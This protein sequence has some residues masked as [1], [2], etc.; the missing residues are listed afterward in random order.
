MEGDDVTKGEKGTLCGVCVCVCAQ[1]CVF[2][3]TC[4]NARVYLLKKPQ[5]IIM[6]HT[7][8][9]RMHSDR[10]N[11]LFRNTIRSL[12]NQQMVSNQP[13]WKTN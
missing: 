5:R 11:V 4:T 6:F 7:Y 12:L 8:R 1:L 2:M 3:C 9:N 13:H 10:T